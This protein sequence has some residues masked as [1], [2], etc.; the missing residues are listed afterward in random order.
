MIYVAFSFIATP[1]P[2]S[3]HHD[4]PRLLRA[5]S[6]RSA[7]QRDSNHSFN[8]F[9]ISHKK[10]HLTSLHV[11]YISTEHVTNRRLHLHTL[12]RRI[13]IKFPVSLL[14]IK[15]NSGAQ[16]YTTQVKRFEWTGR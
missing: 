8:W 6:V 14:S 11:L 2:A 12:A 4:P 15:L 13:R 9:I 7:K 3:I 10:K 16:K 5:W 1:L